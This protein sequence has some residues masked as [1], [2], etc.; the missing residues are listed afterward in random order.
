MRPV[1]QAGQQ[2]NEQQN[3]SQIDHV[4]MQVS[5]QE[6]I[7]GELMD[8]FVYRIG[9]VADESRR[10]GKPECSA[11]LTFNPAVFECPGKNPV[12]W[13]VIGIEKSMGIAG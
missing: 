6:R 8:G 7:I 11:G 4:G 10:I 5:H 9:I 2:A 13:A 12:A 1:Q 3:Q